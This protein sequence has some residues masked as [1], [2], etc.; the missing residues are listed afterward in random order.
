VQPQPRSTASF[1]NQKQDGLAD[2]AQAR[3]DEAVRVV[4]RVNCGQCDTLVSVR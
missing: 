4:A 1:S 2:A 3:V